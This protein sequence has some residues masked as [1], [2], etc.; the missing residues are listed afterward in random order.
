MISQKKHVRGKEDSHY[1]K[2]VDE[3]I[4]TK[5]AEV[6][7]YNFHPL[8]LAKT[9]SAED[10]SPLKPVSPQSSNKG[11]APLELL[12]KNSIHIPLMTQITVVNKEI[13]HF[14]LT[15]QNLSGNLHAMCN[16]L[17]LRDN[18]F[19][20]N[21][22]GGLVEAMAEDNLTFQKHPTSLSKIL[23]HAIHISSAASVDPLGAN[24]GKPPYLF[25]HIRRPS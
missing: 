22:G 3:C 13:L 15:N 2:P 5:D 23:K 9:K 25:F 11:L 16:Y 10:E 4:I 1:L 7:K 17:L 20:F 14:F 12:V 19:A 8:K 18:E 6:L 21:L 24:V